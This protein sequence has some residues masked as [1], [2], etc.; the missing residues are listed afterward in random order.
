MEPHQ[1]LF[2]VLQYIEDNIHSKLSVLILSREFNI[3]TAHLQRIFKFAFNTPII[4]YIRS[5][6]ISSSINY[7]LNTDMHIID[8]A[9]EYGFEHEQSY[10]RA[11]KR[12][13]QIPPGE[14]RKKHAI[15]KITPPSV[16]P[17]SL[18]ST[19]KIDN[20]IVMDMEIVLV[21]EFFVVGKRHKVD[22]EKSV[23]L[24]PQLAKDFFYH[25]SK[26]IPNVINPNVYIGLTTV[27]ENMTDWTYYLP[28]VQVKDIQN[29]PDDLDFYKFNSCMCAKFKYIGN[30]HYT[31]INRQMAGTMYDS[32]F[33]FFGNQN[34]YHP[35]IN[36][37]FER[38][39]TNINDEE[40]CLMEWF[41]PL[42]SR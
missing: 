25:D 9:Y 1:I 2:R 34:Q 8:I 20:G 42:I 26:H 41:A 30:H 40:Y 14:A 23:F 12:E 11:F 21:P 5:R 31:E 10:I 28:S 17:I 29:I 33:N 39:D 16:P 27:P 35:T 7:L 6:K 13:H 32:I 38:I 15:L 37:H 19:T 36:L 3:S 22:V 4:S 18:S 24:A